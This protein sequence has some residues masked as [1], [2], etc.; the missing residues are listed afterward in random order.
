MGSTARSAAPTPQIMLA[1]SIL[2]GGAAVAV[3]LV[4]AAGSDE[5]SIEATTDDRPINTFPHRHYYLGKNN[6]ST[7]TT[8]PS[9]MNYLLA[10]SSYRHNH[11][12]N[13]NNNNIIATSDASAETSASKAAAARLSQKS[14]PTSSGASSS[15]HLNSDYVN[16]LRSKRTNDTSNSFKNQG[17]STLKRSSSTP[18]IRPPFSPVAKSPSETTNADDDSYPTFTQYHH[19]LLKKYLT[20]QVWSRL[21]HLQTSFGTTIEDIIRPGLALP[22]GANPPRRVGVLVGDAECYTVFKELLDPIISEYHGIDSYEEWMDPEL[23]MESYFR[24]MAQ[25]NSSSSSGGGGGT[26]AFGATHD[27][28]NN[29]SDLDVMKSHG[30]DDDSDND[31]DSFFFL[32]EEGDLYEEDVILSP[33]T[34]TTSTAAPS[35]HTTSQSA[36]TSSMKPTTSTSPTKS[37]PTAPSHV[38]AIASKRKTHLRRHPT[39]INNPRL[40]TNRV[41]DPDGNYIVSTRIRVAR[42][43]DGIRFPSSMSRADRRYI[44]RLIGECTRNFHSPKLAYGSYISVLSMTND[45]NLDLI[46]RHILF[47]NPNEWT[48]SSGLGRDWPDGRALYANVTNVQSQTPDFM[49]WVN[50]EDHLRIMCLRSGGDIQGV[51]TT[52][53]NGL[54]EL[55]RE[56]SIRGWHFCYDARLGYLTSCPTNVGT[57]MRASVHVRLVNLG[58]LPGFFELVERLKLEVR[59]MYGET[60]RHYTGIFDIS[61]AERLGK[62]EVHLINVMVDGVAKLIEL[63]RKLEAGEQVDISEIATS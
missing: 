12:H 8:N 60:D 6:F 33:T 5:S 46:E 24:K 15:S 11:N 43:L 48:I 3:G 52:L 26:T 54:H 9:S 44:E 36:T 10:T 32:D 13:N 53:W 14:S 2:G 23:P 58:R 35:A 38:E 34:T 45:M 4:C 17:S 7:T 20:R 37:S 39:I 47:D 59:G 19:S 22:M 55:E 31:G 29:N 63:E 62:S 50:E 41:A 42:S 27:N 28:N 25:L 21:S 51:F 40:V 18:P 61:N 49:I 1:M 16:N 30:A 56:L 57:A